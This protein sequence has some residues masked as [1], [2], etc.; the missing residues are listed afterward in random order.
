MRYTEC[1]MRYKDG[2]G[3]KV[4]SPYY[5]QIHI[6]IQLSEFLYILIVSYEE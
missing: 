4:A 6:K 1:Y 2:I 5:A 3:R